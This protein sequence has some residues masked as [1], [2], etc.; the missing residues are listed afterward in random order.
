MEN[1]KEYIGI[2]V[3]VIPVMV[4]I[5]RWIWK[6][7]GVQARVEQSHYAQTIEKVVETAIYAVEKWAINFKSDGEEGK[8]ANSEKKKEMAM[9]FVKS[10]ANKLG[11]PKS[12][13]EDE[14]VSGFIE[15]TLLKL[16]DP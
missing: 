1:L 9:S 4:A 7:G 8:K 5:V 2:A 11:V 10:A 3:V 15:A 14:V 13:L 6:L 16:N 12:I